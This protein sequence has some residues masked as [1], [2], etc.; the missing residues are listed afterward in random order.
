V[1]IDEFTNSLNFPVIFSAEEAAVVIDSL[2]VA[3]L[4][5]NVSK[6]GANSVRFNTPKSTESTVV[7]M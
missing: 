5:I 6:R 3:P 7:K 4:D 1:T 2:F